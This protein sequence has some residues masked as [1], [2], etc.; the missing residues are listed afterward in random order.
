MPSRKE[1]MHET[2]RKEMKKLE[3]AVNNDTFSEDK[4]KRIKIHGLNA[5]IEQLL[6]SLPSPR[7]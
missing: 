7:Q 3:W 2:L 6:N 1:V 4:K 5:L